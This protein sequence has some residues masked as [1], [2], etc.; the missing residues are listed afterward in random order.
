MNYY[1]LDR[2]ALLLRAGVNLVWAA[3]TSTNLQETHLLQGSLTLNMVSG[4]ASDTSGSFLEKYGGQI[5]HGV[6][7]L[8]AFCILMPG[9][10]LLA[11]HKWWFT[12]KQVRHLLPHCM[13]LL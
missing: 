5:A 6:F 1:V 9:A 8:L 7:M 13:P 2:V 12:D 10:A 3:H 11:R 4:V